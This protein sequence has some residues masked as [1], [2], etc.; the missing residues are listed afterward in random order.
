MTKTKKEHKIVNNRNLMMFA[1][2][3][4]GD[5]N[6]IR[7]GF[8]GKNGINKLSFVDGVSREEKFRGVLFGGREKI[9]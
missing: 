3:D 2:R 4:V 6:N 5:T 1:K 9:N 8:Q 7:G